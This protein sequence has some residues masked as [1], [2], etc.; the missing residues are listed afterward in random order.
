MI[1]VLVGVTAGI[2]AT[3]VWA[4]GGHPAAVTSHSYWI[5]LGVLAIAVALGL[6]MIRGRPKDSDQTPPIRQQRTADRTS[7]KDTPT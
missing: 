3:P 1:R 6:R 2:A 5:T 4:H 7:P